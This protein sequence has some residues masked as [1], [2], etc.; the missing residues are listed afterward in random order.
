MKK[1]LYNSLE[2]WR[3][4]EPVAYKSAFYKGKLEEICEKFGWENKINKPNGYWTLELCKEVAL[5]CNSKNEFRK[6]YSG[7]Y[8][9]SCENKWLDEC[10]SHMI[11]G[12]KPSGYWTIEKCK[13]AALKYN[14]RKE[15]QK[16]YATVY[17]TARKNNW[18]DEC[19]AHM[20]EI[21]KPQGY[22]DLN[23]CKKAALKCKNRKEFGKKYGGA[24]S[25]VTKNRWLDECFAHMKK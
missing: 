25:T 1:P 21:N 10:C 6:K 19:C 13:E 16:K 23:H 5:K 4:A 20:I 17:Q 11:N 2:E 8:G 9:S 24:Y 7:A 14:F 18:L 15:F 3:K 12:K 22:W